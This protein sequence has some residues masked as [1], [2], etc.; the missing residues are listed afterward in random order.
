MG[1]Q[2]ETTHGRLILHMV[3]AAKLLYAQRWRNIDIPTMEECFGKMS[4]MA[5]LTC[6]VRDK[7][8]STLLKGRKFFM[9]CLLK[10]EKSEVTIY[11]FDDWGKKN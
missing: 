10:T 9:D 3:I 8:G 5:K 11:G 4:E 2:L 1:S 6:L 7:I